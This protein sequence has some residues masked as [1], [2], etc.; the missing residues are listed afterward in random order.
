MNS[1]VINLVF[2]D[3]DE[4][5]LH[6]VDIELEMEDLISEL[7]FLKRGYEEVRLRFNQPM[8]NS[9]FAS[10]VHFPGHLPLTLI[11]PFLSAQE[12][13]ELKSQIQN[14]T[15]VLEV[16]NSRPL[17]MNEI[18][19]NVKAQYDQMAARGREEAEAWNQKKVSSHL[20]PQTL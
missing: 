8:E 17:D 19:A 10:V 5:Y 4:T 18:V 9:N 3:K 7:N 13:K 1:P 11:G 20:L 6:K 15:V 14:D 12:I 16:D 2:Q